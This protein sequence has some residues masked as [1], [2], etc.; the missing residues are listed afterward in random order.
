MP[1]FLVGYLLI[2]VV[3]V[4]L[5]L[6]PFMAAGGA[7]AP[8]AA[9]ILPAATLG[10]AL[11]SHTMRLTRAAVSDILEQPYVEMARL[12]GVGTARLVVRHVLPN[13]LPAVANVMVLGLAWVLTGAVVVEQVFVYPGI[14]DLLVEHVMKRDIPVVQGGALVLATVYV[15]LNLLADGLREEVMRYQ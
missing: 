14:G 1:E 10:I 9:L 5:K 3:S 12:K 8:M 7:T 4:E 11:I 2:A 6:L 13:A 15:G